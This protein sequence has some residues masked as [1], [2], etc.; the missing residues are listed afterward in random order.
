MPAT[1]TNPPKLCDIC[2]TVITDRFVDGR[3][4]SGPWANMC[5]PCYEKH[6]VGLGTGSGQLFVKAPDG[7][8]A[9]LKG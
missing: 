1:Y 4:K 8:F 5:L 6:G 2:Q 9:K 3:T 7:T